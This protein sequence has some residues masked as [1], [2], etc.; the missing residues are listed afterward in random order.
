[1]E[2]IVK[3]R[4]DKQEARADIASWP[5]VRSCKNLPVPITLAEISRSISAD[6]PPCLGGMKT[7][8]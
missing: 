4:A 5:R 3:M 8:P 1:M 2:V 6:M 7:R